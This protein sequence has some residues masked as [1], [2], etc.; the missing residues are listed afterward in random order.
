FH[1]LTGNSPETALFAVSGVITCYGI[2]NFIIKPI[3]VRT[4]P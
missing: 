4:S 2:N 3:M 1:V